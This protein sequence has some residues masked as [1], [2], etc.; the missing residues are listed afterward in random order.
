[1]RLFNQTAVD[2][3]VQGRLEVFFEGT[4]AQV[5]GF[6][7]GT[8]DAQ[9][10]CRQLGFT[11]GTVLS[12]FATEAANPARDPLVFPRAAIT[13]SGCNGSEARLVD[14][15]VDPT[16]NAFVESRA[17]CYS[18]GKPG[19]YL[20]CVADPIAGTL[21]LCTLLPLFVHCS[22]ACVSS[23]VPTFTGTLSDGRISLQESICCHKTAEYAA[24]A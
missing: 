18:S 17:G 8:A 2:N 16:L 12:D 14:C 5:C 10:A 19:L 13:K 22:T 1:M 6:A 21:L 24:R 3:W 15:P 7:F 20:A 11:A 9:V 4:W 23:F